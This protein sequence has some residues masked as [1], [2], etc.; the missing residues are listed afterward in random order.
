[1]RAKDLLDR[2]RI[3]STCKCSHRMWDHDASMCRHMGCE[4]TNYTGRWWFRENLM[5]IG[6]RGGKN[7]IG[8]IA[9]SGT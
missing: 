3:N 9:G 8:A 1:M 4:C 5:V 2:I 6:R 7:H